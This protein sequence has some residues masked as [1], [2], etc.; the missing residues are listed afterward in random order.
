MLGLDVSDRS[1]KVIDLADNAK[2]KLRTACWSPLA[3][4]L[5]RRG[6]IQD[7]VGVVAGIKEALTRCTGSALHGSTVVLSIP[8]TQSFV[9]AIELP[10]MSA[11]ETDE[12]VQWAIRQHIPFDLDRVYIDW[13]PIPNS[14]RSDRQEVLVGAAQ[15]DVIDP[16][17]EVIDL[18]GLRVV[19]LELEAQA[20]V[21]ALLPFDSQTITGIVIVDIG[22]TSTN[23]IFFDRGSI[24]FTIS[25]QRGGDDLTQELAQTLRIAP[26]QAAESKAEA[27][28]D[29]AVTSTIQVAALSLI[30]KIGQIVQDMTKKYGIGDD[31][32]AILLSGGSANL[33]GIVDLFAQVFPGVPIQVGNPLVNLM[34]DPAKNDMPIS[35]E[36]AT[37]FATAIGLALRTVG[38]SER[39]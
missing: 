26:Q 7:A 6:V 38:Y 14:A 9:R 22:A 13:Q 27:T 33:P 23:V 2:H 4:N 12:A 28:S 30:N 35:K 32:R 29:E 24:R 25:V 16:L 18:V 21:R 31:I 11:W 17:L 5:M 34:I 10:V 8:E 3:P 39:G 37:H 15:R 1:I 36:D 20:I 19:A